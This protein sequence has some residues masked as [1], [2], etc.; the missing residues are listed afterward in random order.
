MLFPMLFWGS[1]EIVGHEWQHFANQFSREQ[2]FSL[3]HRFDCWLFLEELQLTHKDEIFVAE[4]RIT[5]LG[6][7]A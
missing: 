6:L 2:I 3:Q 5:N 4:N 1:K 7:I